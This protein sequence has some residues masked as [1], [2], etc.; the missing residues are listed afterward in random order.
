MRTSQKRVLLLSIPIVGLLAGTGMIMPAMAQAPIRSSNLLGDV[1]GGGVG[2]AL[3]PV[4]SLLG[5]VTG[6]A[7]GVLAPVTGLL[8]L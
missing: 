6:A 2:G 5:G 1:A 7:G 4:T 3:A 8:G